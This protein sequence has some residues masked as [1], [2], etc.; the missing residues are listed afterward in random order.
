MFLRKKL[1]ANRTVHDR[2]LPS[3]GS[4][5]GRRL[6]LRGSALEPLQLQGTYG[7]LASAMKG[8]GAHSPHPLYYY[9]AK[10]YLKT[11]NKSAAIK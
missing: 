11:F 8:N 1:R 7:R 4:T 5:F 3:L 10:G 9:N 2:L 6:T